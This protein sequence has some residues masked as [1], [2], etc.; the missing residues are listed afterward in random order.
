MA[1]KPPA[2]D[3]ETS[4]HDDAMDPGTAVERSNAPQNPGL[5]P[6]HQRVTDLDDKEA[7]GMER[8]ISLF[9]LLSIVGSVFAAVAY[10]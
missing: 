6:E 4:G 1:D 8:R 5:A 9:F 2:S 7:K 10:V 3:V